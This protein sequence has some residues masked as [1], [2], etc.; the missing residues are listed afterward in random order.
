[1]NCID[2]GKDDVEYEHINRKKLDGNVKNMSLKIS[3]VN[4]DTID[5]YDTSC[6]G[7]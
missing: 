5:S 1:M 6:H 4:Y 7:Y 2:D 3:K